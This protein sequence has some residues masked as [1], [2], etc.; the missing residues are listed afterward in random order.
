MS[1]SLGPGG[2]GSA[3]IGL[4]GCDVVEPADCDLASGSKIE[5]T[6]HLVEGGGEILEE[7]SPPSGKHIGALQF[8]GGGCPLAGAEPHLN[9]SFAAGG[10][11]GESTLGKPLSVSEAISTKAGLPPLTL[12]PESATMTGSINLQLAYPLSTLWK[13]ISANTESPGVPTGWRSD[14]VEI[15]QE[16]MVQLNAGPVNF[17]L[18]F[19]GFEIEVGCNSVGDSDMSLISDAKEVG[20]LRFE[21]CSFIEPAQCT[22]PG[23]TITT[24]MVSASLS[25]IDGSIYETFRPTEGA[26]FK[27]V[28]QGGSCP[29][30]GLEPKVSGSFTGVGPYLGIYN[31]IQ[32]VEVTPASNASA[33]SYLI[34]GDES[35]ILTGTFE[36]AL[37][38]PYRWSS[39]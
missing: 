19:L 35:G 34:M 29:L 13:A 32:P 31:S 38:T 30:A 8:E 10:P 16:E 17:T 23:G 26:F 12:G 25:V 1:G 27:L 37:R 6:T 5:A 15:G 11:L 24:E 22:V 33:G 36:Q 4:S 2:G 28:I 9:G 3:T 20:S 18:G 14:E 7:F 39:Y 21:G